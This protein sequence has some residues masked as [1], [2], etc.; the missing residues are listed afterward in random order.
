MI[1]HECN[2]WCCRSQCCRIVEASTIA[3]CGFNVRLL[4]LAVGANPHWSDRLR[5][6]APPA[7]QERASIKVS[8]PLSYCRLGL[9]NFSGGDREV[10]SRFARRKLQLSSRP[11]E[12]RVGVITAPVCHLSS[13]DHYVPA[14]KEEEGS[15]TT[16]AVCAPRYGCCVQGSAASF[17]QTGVWGTLVQ[18]MN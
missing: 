16:T 7:W 13:L 1:S 3:H 6:M 4:F 5:H 9:T 10:S 8:R 2:T 14:K 11:G 12:S 15:I 18:T 17:L